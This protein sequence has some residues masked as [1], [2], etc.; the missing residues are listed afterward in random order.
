LGTGGEASNCGFEDVF[1]ILE[2]KIKGLNTKSNNTKGQKT[3]FFKGQY[4]QS[5]HFVGW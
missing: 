3:G 1:E 5:S 2:E 4:M